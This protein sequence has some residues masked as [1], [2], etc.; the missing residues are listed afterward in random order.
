MAKP[1]S[2][3]RYY[4]I[5]GLQ[6]LWKGDPLVSGSQFREIV[7]TSNQWNSTEGTFQTY[8]VECCTIGL[9]E[10][11]MAVSREPKLLFDSDFEGLEAAAKKFTEL[12]ADARAQGYSVLS[13]FD[14]LDF[15]AP[16]KRRLT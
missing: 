8:A 6:S 12:S 9:A 11:T 3:G 13:L 2:H 15:Q 1:T 4:F 10:A 14:E 16:A 7:I 5:R